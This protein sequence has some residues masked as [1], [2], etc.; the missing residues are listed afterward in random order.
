M[1]WYYSLVLGYEIEVEN[2]D[3]IPSDECEEIGFFSKA[4]LEADLIS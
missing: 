3:F 2:L 1:D 4:E